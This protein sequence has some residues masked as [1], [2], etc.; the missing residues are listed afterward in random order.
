MLHATNVEEQNKPISSFLDLP[1]E[2]WVAIFSFLPK[3]NDILSAMQCCHAW[4]A[5]IKE[6]ELLETIIHQDLLFGDLFLDSV[7]LFQPFCDEWGCVSSYPKQALV[8]KF[9]RDVLF[10]LI[11]KYDAVFAGGSVVRSLLVSN[12]TSLLR[13]LQDYRYPNHV[14][15][16]DWRLGEGSEDEFEL[17][18]F[19]QDRFKWKGEYDIFVHPERFDAF[20][21]EITKS[22][23][24][25]YASIEKGFSAD[26]RVLAGA[27]FRRN[28]TSSFETYGSWLVTDPKPRPSVYRDA[29][30][31]LITFQIPMFSSFFNGLYNTGAIEF[32][33]VSTELDKGEHPGVPTL[34]EL[35]ATTGISALEYTKH[36]LDS[37]FDLDFCRVYIDGTRYHFG[38]NIGMGDF[39]RMQEHANIDSVIRKMQKQFPI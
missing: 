27:W 14:E 28:R 20:V 16:V 24:S 15:M 11:S 3:S 21:G 38:A 26:Q 23:T 5:V 36:M 9:F 6:H 7:I 8:Q 35:V 10:K 18:S 22:F 37:S 25:L 13:D 4:D 29:D 1:P 2:I 12:K 31:R 39:F 17:G 33:I 19:R 34:D 32:A 30:F